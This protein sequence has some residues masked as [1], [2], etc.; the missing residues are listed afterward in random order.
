[1]APSKTWLSQNFSFSFSGYV[2]FAILQKVVSQ[3][4]K[5]KSLEVAICIFLKLAFKTLLSLD[6]AIEEV[7]V[8][9]SQN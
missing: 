9:G 1:M 2:R 8:S 6:L 3:S 5:V 7:N 4:L